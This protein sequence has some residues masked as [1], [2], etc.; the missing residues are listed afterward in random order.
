MSAKT[1]L[2]TCIAVG[3]GQQMHAFA[4]LLQP[5]AT[6]SGACMRTSN[7]AP[8]YVHS[9]KARH[10]PQHSPQPVSQYVLVCAPAAHHTPHTTAHSSCT[11]LAPS[12]TTAT[13]YAPAGQAAAA[14]K[15][16]EACTML[17]PGQHQHPSVPPCLLQSWKRQ[18]VTHA[19]PV[20]LV[21]IWPASCPSGEGTCCCC[22]DVPGPIC[23]STP[24]HYHHHHHTTHSTAQRAIGPAVR[25]TGQHHSLQANINSVLK[26]RSH[27]YQGIGQPPGQV[28]VS[29]VIQGSRV[30][31]GS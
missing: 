15:C 2:G 22:N 6:L 13:C 4:C 7:V 5:P 31:R 26:S 10:Q 30:T 23:H 18:P 25:A 11:C 19:D 29:W 20:S 14:H 8:L 17:H 12:Q 24:P 9:I 21:I 16:P 3:G 27:N 28:C 1:R